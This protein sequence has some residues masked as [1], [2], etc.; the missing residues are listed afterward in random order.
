MAV[1]SYLEGGKKSGK[2]LAVGW[3]EK[4]KSVAVTG[5][6]LQVPVDGDGSI[7]STCTDRSWPSTVFRRSPSVSWPDVTV[8]ET[9]W[10]LSSESELL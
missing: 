6:A 10:Y 2:K 9:T 8:P 4:R 7:P 1:A 5:L 3:G